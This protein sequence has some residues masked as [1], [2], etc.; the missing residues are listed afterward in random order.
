MGST[1]TMSTGIS[2][3]S[4]TITTL[5]WWRWISSS[6]VSSPMLSVR[7]ITPSTCYR[8]LNFPTS[9]HASV[10]RSGRATGCWARRCSS[11]SSS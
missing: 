7:F 9:F 1:L 5:P 6:W 4:H 2:S 3:P 10:G 11:S 8:R